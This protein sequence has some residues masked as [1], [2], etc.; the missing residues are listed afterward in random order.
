MQDIIRGRVWTL[1]RD[2]DTDGIISGKYPDGHR[3]QR[4]QEARVRD[5][6]SRVRC[7][8]EGR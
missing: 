6:A 3:P 2:V 4:A 8:S 7:G 5:R 1:G